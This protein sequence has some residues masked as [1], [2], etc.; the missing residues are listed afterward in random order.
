MNI[1]LGGAERLEQLRVRLKRLLEKP[2]AKALQAVAS[3]RVVRLA[4]EPLEVWLVLGEHGDYIVI[5]GTY[6]SCPHFTIRVVA[7][8]STMP[9]Y[10]L[11]AV[12]LA[13][14]LDKFIDLSGKLS[15]SEREE[16]IFE[17]IVSERALTAR[18]I[19]FKSS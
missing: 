1:G 17:T 18:R 7:Q 9:C 11:V 6:C 12:E 19:I 8:G 2:P 10:H 4:S 13:K 5:P 15:S 16:I 14:R 3:G